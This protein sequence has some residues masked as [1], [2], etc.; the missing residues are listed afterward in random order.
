[1]PQVKFDMSNR[2]YNPP[3]K[4]VPEPARPLEPITVE[5]PERRK[6]YT[7][8]YLQNKVQETTSQLRTDISTFKDRMKSKGEYVQ[9]KLEAQELLNNSAAQ[10][11][12][13]KKPC[14]KSCGDKKP[15]ESESSPQIK[16]TQVN[17]T[18]KESLFFS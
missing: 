8:E 1:M 7:K 4:V 3:Q 16:E 18:L 11:L 12:P 10:A 5:Q 15:C 9:T 14:C 6:A 2:G 13:K 17:T